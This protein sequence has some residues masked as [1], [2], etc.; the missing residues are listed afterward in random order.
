MDWEKSH[1]VPYDLRH[2]TNDPIIV[3]WVLDS[4]LRD[5]V[6]VVTILH[7]ALFIEDFNR[8]L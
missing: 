4:P 8:D 3:S 6:D 1:I 7:D 5:F 2:D